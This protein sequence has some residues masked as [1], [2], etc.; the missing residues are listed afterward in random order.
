MT[1]K[2]KTVIFDYDG[3]LN[4]S[5]SCLKETWNELYRQNL[6]K[7]FFRTDEEFSNYFHGDP[8]RNIIEVG[9]LEEDIPKCNKII[10][11][12]LPS[13]DKNACL[14]DG[15]PE[16]IKSLKEKGYTIGV[17]SNALKEMV[18]YK[19]EKYGLLN[20]VDIIIGRDEVKEPKPSPEGI[21][22]CLRKLNLNPSQAI[23]V[24]D[25]ESDIKAS[26]NANVKVIATKYGYLKYCEKIDERLNGADIKVET[27]EQLRKEIENA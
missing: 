3:V 4:D 9:V 17:V 22:L 27:V 18:E 10:R 15:I 24:G 8:K 14:Y 25:M 11:D 5:L 21:K 26:K 16:L 20:H 23:Y 2:V 13:L 19:L 12:F 6:S 7:K 1:S